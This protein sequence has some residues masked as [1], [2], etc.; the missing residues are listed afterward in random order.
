MNELKRIKPL[1]T[2]TENRHSREVLN[3]SKFAINFSKKK[4]IHYTDT[5]ATADDNER[6]LEI[7]YRLRD[8]F[9]WDYRLFLFMRETFL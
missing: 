5:L 9:I 8:Y 3:K 6:T 1:C 7:Q 2:H 4:K